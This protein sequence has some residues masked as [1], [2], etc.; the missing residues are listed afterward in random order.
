MAFSTGRETLLESTNEMRY[1]TRFAIFLLP[2]K[3]RH[4]R[5]VMGWKA[6]PWASLGIVDQLVS[7]LMRVAHHQTSFVGEFICCP[8]MM[9]PL[10]C[11]KQNPLLLYSNVLRIFCTYLSCTLLVTAQFLYYTHLLVR[12][13]IAAS[14]SRERDGA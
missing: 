14:H 9:N 3:D 12:I 1:F 5:L 11:S 10:G 6:Q 8:F 7:E 13:D 4:G 2:I